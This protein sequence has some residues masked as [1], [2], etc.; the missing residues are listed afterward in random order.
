MK[1]VLICGGTGSRLFPLTKTVN[2]QLMPVYDQPLVH[3]P[4]RTLIQAGVDNVLI[5]SG[6]EHADQFIQHF[7]D[8]K[9]FEHVKF[10]YAIQKEPGGIAQALGLAENFFGDDP[11]I[12]LLG[13]NI[14]EDDF[15]QAFKE[16]SENPQGSRIFLREVPDPQRFGCPE[17]NPD[18]T[19]CKIIEK[20]ENPP[21][22][23]CVTGLYMYDSSVWDV[24]KTLKPSGRGELEITDVN[25]HY[26][27]NGTMKYHNVA[28][29]WI[30]AGTFN[31]L[32][33]AS[34]WAAK[35]Q[36]VDID[37]LC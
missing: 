10:E 32:L 25:N 12:A 11:V 35:R 16:F 13:D 15:S 9:E 7:S 31:S 28:G 33:K 4:L 17:I 34:M 20:P 18:G 6:I 30:D 36:G 3:Y 21:S 5:V 29:I 24:I 26:V 8:Y 19:I 37:T 22:Q 1:A 2:K 27:F 14:Y 23:F